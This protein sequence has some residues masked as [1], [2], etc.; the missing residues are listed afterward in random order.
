MKPTCQ[1][2]FCFNLHGQTPIFWHK[3]LTVKFDVKYLFSQPSFQTITFVF[4]MNQR[5]SNKKQ[6][7]MS[8]Q[9]ASGASNQ[10]NKFVQFSLQTYKFAPRARWCREP[11]KVIF[12]TSTQKRGGVGGIL[13]F[14]SCFQILLFSNNSLIVHFCG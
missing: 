9:I 5:S 4:M 14:V 7:N 8:Y 6:I 12:M 11:Q 2:I 1:L 10:R 3:I 13:Y